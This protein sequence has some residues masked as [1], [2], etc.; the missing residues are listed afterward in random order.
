MSEEIT[1]TIIKLPNVTIF[2]DGRHAE[3]VKTLVKSGAQLKSEITPEKL[4]LWI[5]ACKVLIEAGNLFDTVKKHTIYNKP[6]DEGA[7]GAIQDRLEC[8]LKEFDQI[9]VDNIVIDPYQLELL[10]IVS[11]LPGEGAEL[12]DMVLEHILNDKPIDLE[13]AKEECGDME[14][15]L[16]GS[17]ARFGITRKDTLINNYTKL[18]KRY[19]GMKYS[20]AAANER[21]DKQND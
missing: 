21:K 17:R 5:R 1:E 12:L 15:Y 9:T 16:E 7:L 4:T 19:E 6:M 13:N 18:G 20:D 14:F 3:M 11:C 8:A 2:E 10:H